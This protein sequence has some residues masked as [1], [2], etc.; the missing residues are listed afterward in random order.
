MW[1]EIVSEAALGAACLILAGLAAADP[2]GPHRL[3][4]PATPD[5]IAAWNID[6]RPDGAGLPPG[7]GSVA[8]GRAVFAARCA[9]CHGET[10]QGGAADR[11]VGGQGTLATAKPVRTVGSFWPYAT[12]LFD[13]VRRAMPFDAPQSLTDAE[14]YAVSTYLL[15]LNGIVPADAVLDARSL[16]A[17]AMPNRAGFVPD[18]RPDVTAR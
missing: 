15:H 1:R 5:A 16:P 11:L 10:G 2:L 14:V 4:R 6:V 13:Y 9:S 8:E 3:G 12:T 7:R 17:V 18:A